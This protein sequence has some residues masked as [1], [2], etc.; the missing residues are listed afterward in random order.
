MFLADKKALIIIIFGQCNEATKTEI[1]LGV[2]YP[3]DR[4]AVNLINFINQ[5]RTVCFGGDDGGLSYGPYKQVVS[6]KSL[7]TYT[8]NKPQDPHGYKEK[9]KIKYKATKAIV[10]KFPNGTAALMELLSKAAD[11]L[12][13]AGYCALPEEDPLLWEVRAYDPHGFKEQIK[14]K[15]EAT[16]AISGKFLTGTAALMELLTNA[17]PALD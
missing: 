9:D 16:K 8:N 13:W 6:I 2:T 3:T 17:Q 5:L 14:I 12:D 1:A 7:N 15:Y 4:Q 10:G 11:P